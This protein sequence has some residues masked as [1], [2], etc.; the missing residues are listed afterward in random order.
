MVTK[1]DNKHVVYPLYFDRAVSRLNGRKV[2]KK[3]AIEKPS[4]EAIAKAAKSLGLN[5]ILEKEAVH[6]STPW[7]KEGRILIDKKGP[8]TQLLLQ[9][10]N[11]L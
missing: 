5:P 4:L 6:S 1:D 9:I 11:R 10:S 3:H 2:A 7:K 8:K